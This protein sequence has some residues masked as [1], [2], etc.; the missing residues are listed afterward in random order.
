VAVSRILAEMETIKTLAL[1]LSTCTEVNRYDQGS[2]REAWTLA[3]GLSDIEESMAKVYND[4]IPALLT[5]T[6]SSDEIYDILLNIREEMRHA[7][8]HIRDPQFFKP[9][10]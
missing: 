8:Y 2:E 5:G 4:L 3:L 6:H 1:V 10:E 9:L 7:L